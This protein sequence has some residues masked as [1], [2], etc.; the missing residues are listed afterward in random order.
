MQESMRQLRNLH[1]A[2]GLGH[3]Q[4]SG[5]EGGSLRTNQFQGQNSL[6]EMAQRAGQPLSSSNVGSFSNFEQD[7]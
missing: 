5:T 1:G 7:Y 4:E 6:Y 3:S 2:Q